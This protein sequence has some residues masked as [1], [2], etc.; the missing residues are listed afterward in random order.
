MQAFRE[1]P[2]GST[3][4][5]SSPRWCARTASRY[6]TNTIVSERT[7]GAQSRPPMASHTTHHTR[8]VRDARKLHE[9]RL[10]LVFHGTCAYL[11]Q[12]PGTGPLPKRGTLAA[13]REI[14]LR[15]GSALQNAH[16]VPRWA[17]R[18]HNPDTPGTCHHASAGCVESVHT[19]D[20]CQSRPRLH[21]AR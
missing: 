20:S 14:A 11:R 2:F 13:W 5:R 15:L 1:Q 7:E 17:A 9:S 12:G 8:L 4:F 6:S 19:E 10:F 21:R 16:Q 3:P 18:E